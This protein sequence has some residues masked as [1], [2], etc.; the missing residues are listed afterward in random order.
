MGQTVS[1]PLS[2]RLQSGDG[3]DRLSLAFNTFWTDLL[4]DSPSSGDVR[5]HF[6]INGKG[7]PADELNLNL[8][9]VLHE[10]ET[11]ETGTGRTITL[12]AEPVELGPDELGG[13]I[14][15]HGWTMKVDSRARLV[16]PVYPFN[17]Y[18]DGPETS[19]QHAVGRLRVPLQLK[20]QPGHYV[21]PD[22]TQVAF[23]VSVE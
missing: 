21:R 16:W 22:E 11:L 8:Q 2:S 14:R 9:L 5:F 3:Q 6:V 7:T 20:A 12:S 18:G 4:V 23:Q 15:H 10:G 19:L 17:P 13:S 1:I